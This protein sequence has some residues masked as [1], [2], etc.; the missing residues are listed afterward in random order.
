MSLPPPSVNATTAVTPTST[1]SHSR[2]VNV[3]QAAFAALDLM[4]VR[5]RR[6]RDLYRQQYLKWEPRPAELEQTCVDFVQSL[7]T[8]R[9][10]SV[11][12]AKARPSTLLATCTAYEKHV[13]IRCMELTDS[14]RHMVLGGQPAHSLVNRC[15]LAQLGTELCHALDAERSRWA[16]IPIVDNSFVFVTNSA[17]PSDELTRYLAGYMPRLVQAHC[18]QAL[19]PAVDRWVHHN[20]LLHTDSNTYNLIGRKQFSFNTLIPG[21]ALHEFIAA[22]EHMVADNMTKRTVARY[23]S[24]ALVRIVAHCLNSTRLLELFCQTCACADPDYN[25]GESADDHTGDYTAAADLRVSDLVVCAWGIHLRVS[26]LGSVHVHLGMLLCV[27]FV[28]LNFWVNVCDTH[29]RLPHGRSRLE[30]PF[31]RRVLRYTF[32]LR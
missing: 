7:A 23:G 4:I 17:N 22:V 18:P 16:D 29:T 3:V 8:T 20:T 11:N 30:M 6:C 10:A 27:Q 1:A 25:T 28:S 26:S 14:C 9:T 24:D 12:A 31:I 13:I 2:Y 21:P 19:K 15:L 32:S 5:Q